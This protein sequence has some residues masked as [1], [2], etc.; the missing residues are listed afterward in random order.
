MSATSS[1][2]SA[3]GE[4]ARRHDPDRFLCTLFAPPAR[5]ETLLLLVALNH[6]LARARFNQLRRD[7]RGRRLRW[8]GNGG[9][10]CLTV[11][12]QSSGRR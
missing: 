2:L 4:L 9:T 7:D 1:D 6:E 3:V 5:R 10:A 8:L 12:P 11:G